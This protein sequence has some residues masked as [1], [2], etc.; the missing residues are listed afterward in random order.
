MHLLGQEIKVEVEKPD[1][2]V[3][4]LIYEDK[5]DFNWQG[6][7]TLKEPL[8][9]RSGS[10]VRLSCIYDNSANNRHN[11]NNPPK[12]VTWGE[13]T[14]DEMCLAFLG[15]TFDNEQLVMALLPLIL[16]LL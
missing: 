13:A 8:T 2:T 1:R 12:P 7:Y 3:A 4:P 9:I 5:W 10:T 11:P 16:S 6:A 14:T 15:L